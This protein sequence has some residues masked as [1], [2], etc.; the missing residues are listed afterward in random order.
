M[1]T[2]FFYLIKST[3]CLGSLFLVYW[4]FLRRDTFFQ[5][6]RLFLILTGILSLVLPVIPFH[7]LMHEP[8]SALV[9]FL[10]PVL[11]TPGKVEKTFAAHLQWVEVM[12]VIYF[13]GMTI[14]LVRF[15]VQ[16]LQLLL[17]VRRSRVKKADG[18]ILVMVDRGYSPFSFFNLIFINESNVA[19]ENLGA[20]LAHEQIHIRQSHTFDLVLG[21][22]VIM[23]QW[24]NPFAW[25]I[26]RELKNIHEY[27]ADDGVI[28][29]DIPAHDYQQL[30]LN[31]TIG[32]RVNNLANNFNI[33]Q[34][35]KTNRNDDKKTFREMGHKQ[36]DA[37]SSLNYYHG[38]LFSASTLISHPAQDKGK[39]EAGI[40]GVETAPPDSTAKV[41]V[42]EKQPCYPEGED[43][44]S[45][46]IV[47]NIRYPEQAMKN[48]VQGK[49]FVS[50][51][52][53]TDGTITNV[54]I[55]RGIGA[56]CDEEAV[57]V[58]KLMP[59]WKPG[60]VKG[61]P[62]RTNFV[63]PIRFALDSGKKDDQ[64]EKK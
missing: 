61:K 34:L 8:V 6:N 31:E 4:I 57:R 22:L 48:K 25:L 37:G 7:R 28:R 24:F 26:N 59:K 50:F 20:I 55:M 9:L 42:P 64:K 62:V 23:I 35:K 58:I 63:I 43:A 54:K 49:V 21:E 56:G 14:F 16:I 51:I 60:E 12:Q 52:V 47:E 17:L 36:N 44:R 53:E 5:M 10:D 38:L 13:M 39:L 32:I 11:I 18:C 29:K 30:I 27:L 46:F 2:L 45:K 33:S 19:P 41:V 15:L 40:P 1:N 3:F